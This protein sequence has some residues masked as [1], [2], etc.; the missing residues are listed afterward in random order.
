ME[1][2][3][4]IY[5]TLMAASFYT[6]S[7]FVDAMMANIFIAI[8][9]TII[10]Y[11]IL[12]GSVG[13]L[14]KLKGFNDDFFM[15]MISFSLFFIN[16]F[17]EA[18][19][20][21]LIYFFGRIIIENLIN[22][23]KR[24]IFNNINS[25]IDLANLVKAGDVKVVAASSV[26]PGDVIIVYKDEMIPCDGIITKGNS[27]LN[28]FDL[29]GEKK[30]I[31]VTTGDKVVNETIN[32][33]NPLTIK[34]T[35]DLKSSASAKI[36]KTLSNIVDDSAYAKKVIRYNNMFSAIILT[37]LAIILITG[38]IATG[39]L[40]HLLYLG[41]SFL[42]IVAPTPV[43]D[44]I[45]YSYYATCSKLI[46]RGVL[47]KKIS[48]LDD[49]L[50][51]DSILFDKSSTITDG[52]LKIVEV[53]SEKISEKEL[54]Q[55]IATCE[56]KSNH[57]ITKPFREYL[58]GKETTKFRE[59]SGGIKVNIEKDKYVLGKLSFME[60]NGIN[61]KKAKTIGSVIYV[62]K[63]NEFL[64]YV[65]LRDEV[66]E[67]FAEDVKNIAKLG[68]NDLIVLSSDNYEYVES[69]CRKLDIAR[70]LPDIS[71]KEKLAYIENAQK[72]GVKLMLIGEGIKDAKLLEKATM[73]VAIGKM[74]QFLDLENCDMIIL[75]NNLDH[76]E[77]TIKASKEN[78]RLLSL[79]FS[80]AILFKTIMILMLAMGIF[81][82][83]IGI[84][85]NI[86]IYI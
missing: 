11:D 36:A 51:I 5:K 45:K 20:I 71:E 56:E 69:L 76:I 75:N 66:K 24:A 49:I 55:I 8:G 59:Y 30:L 28:T 80:L 38:Y 34:V 18:L 81:D 83:G 22:K 85:T 3:N 73:G 14:I 57:E 52:K 63:N 9:L 82:L 19:S 68:I 4:R 78:R 64:G 50:E 7:L 29:T 54:L 25:E 27:K 10:S 84:F 17:R 40:E 48:T 35:N 61:V 42:I 23:I 32:V 46:K 15:L 6:A 74:G 31:D 33:G 13:R 21:I 2:K 53:Y 77:M 12:V 67:D 1:F 86:A 62:A 58:N 39:E 60:S 26:K 44:T 41:L 37:A 16:R 70:F 79:N 43:S 47:L 65:V 72:E